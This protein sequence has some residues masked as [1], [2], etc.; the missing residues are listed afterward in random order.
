MNVRT[1]P[2]RL[3]ALLSIAAALSACGG[4]EQKAVSP[5]EITR[6]TVCTLD[7]MIL[8][9]FP[10]PKAQIFYDKPEP[11]F[12]CDT[13]EMFSIYLKPEQQRRVRAMFVQDMGKADWKEPKGNWI[14]AHK[15]FY[16]VGSKRHGSMGPTLA[17]FA[18]EADA[19]AFAAKEGGKVYRF[20][21]VTPDMVTLDGGVLKDHKM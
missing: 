16:V 14:D 18:Q 17:S 19:T 2:T 5:V 12:F 8:A 4:S 15:A 20:D 10:G 9:D 11:D 13:V 6:E 1:T 7:G 21:Q 3:L